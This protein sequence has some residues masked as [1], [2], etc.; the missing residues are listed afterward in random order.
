MKLS[1]K[2]LYKKLGIHKIKNDKAKKIINNSSWL[3]SDKIF[4][5][6]LGVFVSAITARYFGPEQFGQFNYALAFVSLFTAFSTLGLEVLTVK[7]LVEKEFDEGTIL[8]TSLFLRIFGGVFLTIFTTL[9]IRL[10]E[11]KDYNLQIIV[12]IMSFSM[13]IKS[14]DVIEYW[15]QAHQKAKVSSIIRMVVTIITSI[16]KILLVLLKGNLILFA[17][18]YTVDA[19]IISFALLIAYFKIRESKSNWRFNL[20]MLKT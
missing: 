12:L 3:V 2:I 13:T 15:I 20:F 1:L 14:L 17:C 7:S 4:T 6:L 16:L 9:I 18:I 19:I 10:I 5:L 8:C 11:P